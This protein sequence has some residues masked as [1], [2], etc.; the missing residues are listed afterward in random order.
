[1]TIVVNGISDKAL[2]RLAKKAA[3]TGTSEMIDFSAG[4]FNNEY[5][6]KVDTFL[7]DSEWKVTTGNCANKEFVEI[8]NRLEEKFVFVLTAGEFDSVTIA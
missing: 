3:D 4:Y 5:V 7:K 1:M 6:L 2:V 8:K